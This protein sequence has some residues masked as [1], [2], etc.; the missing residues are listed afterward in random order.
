[1]QKR[2]GSTGLRLA[3]MTFLVTGL[4]AV[5]ISGCGGLD[6][7]ECLKLRG[8]AFEIVNEA[9]PCGSDADCE[10]SSWPGCERPIS[11]KNKAR[12]DPLA[13][14]FTEGKCKDEEAREC[15]EPPTVYCKQGLCVFR[16]EAGETEGK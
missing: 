9:H 2:S 15:P 11:S 13:A 3:A 8:E 6:E 10:L 16:H 14:K 4:A 7:K 5:G 1:M 12:I